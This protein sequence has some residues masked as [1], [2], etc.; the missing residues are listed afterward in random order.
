MS[1]PKRVVVWGTGFV[2]KMVIPEIVRH[3]AFELVGVGVSNPD[4]VG[5]D[6]IYHDASHPSEW[7][8]PVSSDPTWARTAFLCFISGIASRQGPARHNNGPG[9]N[10]GGSSGRSRL[11]SAG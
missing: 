11:T 10:H 3:P 5:R 9:G 6:T 2:G 4:K 7:I 1:A 8:L